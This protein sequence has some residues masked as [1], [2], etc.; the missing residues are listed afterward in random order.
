[1]IREHARKVVALLAA[2]D[3]QSRMQGATIRAFETMILDLEYEHAQRAATEWIGSQ[4]WPPSIAELR[5][6]AH[7]L[8][9]GGA[10]LTGSDAWGIL[11]AAV[12]RVGSYDPEPEW[13]EPR[14]GEALKL[15][16]SWRDF[17]LS[18][19]DDAAGRAR[20]ID[21]YDSLV[22]RRRASESPVLT[23]GTETKALA[24]GL[25]KQLTRGASDERAIKSSGGRDASSDGAAADAARQDAHRAPS[26]L[27]HDAG[28]PA[29]AGARGQAQ[30]AGAKHARGRRSPRTRRGPGAG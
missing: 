20:F 8:S 30:D 15:F 21:H 29:D 26:E 28:E 18:P 1:M 14:I 17:C 19:Q 24:Q 10:E 7:A 13:P 3:P 11:L 5:E 27:G 9:Q 6:A 16:G 22:Q 23:A 12:R 2:S 4:K 25:A